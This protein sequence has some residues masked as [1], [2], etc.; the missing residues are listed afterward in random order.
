M[1]AAYEEYG[2]FSQDFW[3]S[4]TPEEKILGDHHIL[5]ELIR[6]D[7]EA[8]EQASKKAE[9]DR[10]HPGMERFKSEDDFWAEV[11]EAGEN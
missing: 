5:N 8:Q 1:R 6:A 10:K 11:E 3:D 7:N 9:E 4:L 2:Y